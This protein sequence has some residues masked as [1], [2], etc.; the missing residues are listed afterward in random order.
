MDQLSRRG[1]LIL[2]WASAAF[3][4]G[5]RHGSGELSK[6]NSSS[7]GKSMSSGTAASLPLS[8]LDEGSGR[9]V[10]V[11]FSLAGLQPGS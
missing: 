1:G 5:E 11:I 2:D 3:R 10:P 4:D 6:D 8:G 7:F 9:E